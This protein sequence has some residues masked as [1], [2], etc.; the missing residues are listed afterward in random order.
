MQK[1]VHA[2][3]EQK[4]YYWVKRGNQPIKISIPMFNK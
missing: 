4:T 2:V 3:I 1:D